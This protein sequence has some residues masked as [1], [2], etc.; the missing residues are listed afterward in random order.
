MLLTNDLFSIC[1]EW[2]KEEADISISITYIIKKILDFNNIKKLI[3]NQP[4]LC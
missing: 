3:K 4:T 2:P 1:I